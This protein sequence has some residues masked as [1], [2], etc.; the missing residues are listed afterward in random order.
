MLFHK[1]YR[2]TL[3]GHDFQQLNYWSDQAIFARHLN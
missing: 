2:A 1:T 3:L